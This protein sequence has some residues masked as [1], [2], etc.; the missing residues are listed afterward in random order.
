[1]DGMPTVPSRPRSTTDPGRVLGGWGVPVV[2]LLVALLVAVPAAGLSGAAAPVVLGD[3]G[4]LVRWGMPL[5]GVVHSVTAALT[6]GLLV[7]AAFLVREGRTTDRRGT[8]ARA[9]EASALVWLVATAVTLYL[10]YGELAGL[11]PGTPG[12]LG[13]VLASAWPLEPMRLVTTE[14]GLV[15]ALVVLLL[16]ARTRAA[17][18]WSAAL[19]ATA[20]VPVAFAGH[21][22]STTGHETAVT[23]LG[24][25][26]LGLS[27]WVGGLMALAL[28]LPVLGPALPDTVRRFS[29]LAGWAY[30]TVAL[31]GILFATGSVGGPG[32]LATAYGILVLLKAGLLVVLGVGG[33]LQRRTVVAR[34]VDSPARF[35]RLAVGELVLL[36]AAVGLG[37]VLGRTPPPVSERADRDIVVDLTGYPLP[38]PWSW[39]A[40]VTE[41]RV[42]WLF[43]LVAL[44]AVGLYVRGTL[45]LRAR[46]DRWP[47][48]RL[49][50]WVLG[51]GLFVF[52]T[53]G[54]PGVY[55]RVMFSV[56]MVEHMALMMFVPILLVPAQAITLAVRA[57]PARRDRTLGPR[58]VLLAV[59][60]SGWAKIV[61]NPAVAGLMFFGSLVVF[62]WS[63][64]LEWALTTHVGHVFMV[65]HF[66]LTGYA[67]VWSLVGQDPGPPKWAAPFRVM[68]LL[69]TLAA[70]AFFGLSIMQGSWLLAPG[71]FKALQVP[72]VPDLLADQQLGGMIA[73]GIGEAPTVILML[74]VA[75]DWMRR[76]DREARRS[77]R[78]AERDN[79]A[80]LEAY[81]ARLQA[82]GQRGR[83]SAP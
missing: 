24:L 19:A 48:W 16:W 32:G 39:G 1:M 60:H 29:T 27:V 71:F 17:L 42:D 10:T 68:V 54:G 49:L 58:E 40:M 74:M 25:H 43:T 65:V 18:A 2:V 8:A 11:A 59:V 46:G 30:A 72:W 15:A 23:G 73:W 77:D 5:V 20:L 37:V 67:F 7:V 13:Q 14:L 26:L 35:A 45:R 28:L 52:V 33:W 61:V 81:N 34:G 51:W 36:A 31:S 12:Y 76:D 3:A 4:P 21:S 9:A 75:V 82:L 22:T 62:Y 78:Q 79:D 83:S 53:S 44:L 47:L 56:H 63:G 50:V 38:E 41:W 57:M 70:H 69:A 55:G 64:L 66:S 6:V 80:E